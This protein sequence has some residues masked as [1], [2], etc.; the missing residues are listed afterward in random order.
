MEISAEV[1]GVFLNGE[2]I[3][4]PKV[5]V[6]K[7]SKIEEGEQGSVSFLGNMKYEA[8]LY[9]T[10]ASVVLVPKDFSPSKAVQPTM[11][12]VEDVY[13]SIG[14]LMEKFGS[15]EKRTY[16]ISELAIIDSTS[17]VSKTCNVGHYTIIKEQVIIGEDTDIY[18]QVFVGAHVQIG[19][20]CRIMP[21]VKIYPNTKI[22]NFVT[23]HAGTVIGCDGFGYSKDPNGK[24]HKIQH[25]GNV[26]IEDNVEIGANTVIDRAT[27]GSTVIRKGVKLDN[28]I[29]IAHNVEIGEDTVMAAQSGVAGSSKIGERV[30][31][32]GQ[33]GI[34]GHRKIADEVQIQAQSGVISNVN[35]V[36]KRLYGYPAIEYTTYL[37]AFAYMKDLPNLAARIKKLEELKE[38][39]N[40]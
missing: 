28:L 7:P 8:Y 12:R 23:I 13:K 25:L 2:V 6:S 32:G 36:G 5:C 33:A 17:H 37:R 40:K 19:K 34:V 24:Y 29:Q 3:G 22:G 27:M 14:M 26:V 21:G 9:K 4:D 10:N 39:N 16:A 38:P 31:V 30:V 1:L 18:D 35:E 11:I 15:T 20:G